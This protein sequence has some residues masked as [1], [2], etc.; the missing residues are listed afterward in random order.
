MKNINEKYPWIN[1]QINLQNLP[2]RTWFLLGECISKC[3]HISQIPLLPEVRKEL[4]LIYLS[5]GVHATTAIEGNTLSEQQVRDIL[6]GKSTPQPSKQYLQQEV[7]NIIKACNKIAGRL[8]QGQK[9]NLT[10]D[11]LKEYDAWVLAQGVPVTDN[12]VVGEFRTDRRG[13]GG[14]RAPLPEDVPE[15]ANR[16]CQWFEELNKL[17]I[18]LESIAFSVLKAIVGICTLN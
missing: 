9:F 10:I 6:D 7:E 17:E 1:Y 4:H 3:R 14:Y 15:L 2:F 18:D 5:K 12:A 16:F 11:L 8:S 13:V